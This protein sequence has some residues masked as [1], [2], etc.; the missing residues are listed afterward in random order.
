MPTYADTSEQVFLEKLSKKLGRPIPADAPVRT[1]SGPPDFWTSVK[2]DQDTLVQQFITNA[3]KLTVKIHHV[4]NQNDIQKKLGEVFTEIR[5]RSVICWDSPQLRDLNVRDACRN[6]GM[7]LTLWDNQEDRQTM[8]RRCASVDAGITSADY[9]VAITGSLAILGSPE[10]SRSVSL[11]PPVHIAIL[12]K[13]NIIPHMGD[14]LTKLNNT[15]MPSS[16]SFITGPSRTS[17][18]EMDLALGVHGPGKVYIF[19]YN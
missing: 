2:S 8:I 12:K 6:L 15:E 3:E 5:A 7:E 18:I 16:L 11:L 14:I 17:D 4:S 1:V 19:I 10:K 13:D 9:G